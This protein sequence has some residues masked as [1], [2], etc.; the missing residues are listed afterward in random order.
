MVLAKSKVVVYDK[1]FGQNKSCNLAS[2][3]NRSRYQKQQICVLE[4]VENGFSH[5]EAEISNSTDLIE[6]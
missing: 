3:L 1:S 2:L 6:I 5:F 4:E